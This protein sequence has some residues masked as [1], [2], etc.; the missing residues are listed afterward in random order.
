MNRA[1]RA[2]PVSYI[3][4]V[5]LHGFFLYTRY[6]VHQLACAVPLLGVGVFLL[7]SRPEISAH[8]RFKILLNGTLDYCTGYLLVLQ[9]VW[10][11]KLV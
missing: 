7:A 3:S 5:L 10:L 4:V 1:P 6:G 2:F 8:L 11:T 9:V